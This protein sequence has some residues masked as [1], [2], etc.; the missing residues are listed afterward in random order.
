MGLCPYLI[1]NE[2]VA[3]EFV[4]SAYKT[5]KF[6]QNSW[7]LEEKFYMKLKQNVNVNEG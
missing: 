3:T 4:S 2:N 5:K 6:A 7:A 1:D